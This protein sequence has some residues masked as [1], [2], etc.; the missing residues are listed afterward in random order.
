MPLIV[1]FSKIHP[2]C[3]IVIYNKNT[4]LVIQITKIYFLIYLVFLHGSWFIA[5]QTLRISQM[6]RAIKVSFVM[7]MR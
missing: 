6:A 2:S 7:L 1:Y 4:Y 3:D 5:P